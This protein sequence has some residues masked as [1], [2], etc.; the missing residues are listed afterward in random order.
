MN[1]VQNEH[2]QSESESNENSQYFTPTWSNLQLPN[3]STS[4]VAFAAFHLRF[5]KSTI[6]ERADLCNLKRGIDRDLEY[7]IP[8][9]PQLALLYDAFL[10]VRVLTVL[11][12][13]SDVE[14]L[15]KAENAEVL[16]AIGKGRFDSNASKPRKYSITLLIEDTKNCTFSRSLLD[17]MAFFSRLGG[18][19][20]AV[21]DARMTILTGTDATFYAN[22]HGYNMKSGVEMALVRATENEEEIESAFAEVCW[23]DTNKKMYKVIKK[24]VAG[25]F[26]AIGVDP[27][28]SLLSTYDIE[29]STIDGAYKKGMQESNEEFWDKLSIHSHAPNIDY[30]LS[31]GVV[32]DYRTFLKLAPLELELDHPQVYFGCL[33]YKDGM[34]EE[35]KSYV[36]CAMEEERKLQHGCPPEWPIGL[37]VPWTTAEKD[38]GLHAISMSADWVSFSGQF[39]CFA[40][41]GAPGCEV[42]KWSNGCVP[43]LVHSLNAFDEEFKHGKFVLP[44]TQDQVN[45][46]DQNVRRA[47]WEAVELGLQTYYAAVMNMTD[48]ITE[49]DNSKPTESIFDCKKPKT[50][51][52]KEDVALSR[53]VGIPMSG[54]FLLGDVYG[55][56]EK[57][58]QKIPVFSEF[59]SSSIERMG[60]NVSISQ[61]MSKL[62]EFGNSNWKI[63]SLE[64]KV[65]ELKNDIEVLKTSKKSTMLPC[66][67]N[68]CSPAL[69]KKFIAFMNLNPVRGVQIDLPVHCGRA[70]AIARALARAAGVEYLDKSVPKSHLSACEDKGQ[71]QAV[72]YMSTAIYK[73]DAFLVVFRADKEETVDFLKIN[74]HSLGA[75][76][77]VPPMSV[78]QAVERSTD[79]NAPIL[80]QY[81]ESNNKLYALVPKV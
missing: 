29:S 70:V 81:H 39:S 20:R 7:K 72:A 51:H 80:M 58:G 64:T 44:C 71:V 21:L 50:K 36:E 52:S 16:A 18:T 33:V 3:P 77:R 62:L 10:A 35:A 76:Q 30:H 9:D 37:R 56:V 55:M 19:Q 34:H 1:A 28:S 12:N 67:F 61:A 60:P 49:E 32:A 8:I 13:S 54:A 79:G 27:P 46:D 45:C 57:S 47:Q 38:I 41:R 15:V 25:L 78:V 69:A 17:C 2:V 26:N 24:V 66:P 6:P 4:F 63:E 53:M 11:Q 40:L 65:R 75:T 42:S 14:R 43:R 31:F 74:Q 68:L 22:K 48:F 73:C 23:T 59:L 5:T